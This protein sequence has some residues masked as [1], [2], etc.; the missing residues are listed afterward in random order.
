MRSVGLVS[1]I[2]SVILTLPATASML[3]EILMESEF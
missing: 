2:P 1:Y 3:I